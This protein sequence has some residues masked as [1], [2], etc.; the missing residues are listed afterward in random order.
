M[1]VWT[2]RRR[3]V[4]HCNHVL[5]ANPFLY[6]EHKHL[7]PGNAIA[8]SE[9]ARD[10]AVRLPYS[11]HIR[12]RDPD[13]RLVS[14]NEYYNIG[15]QHRGPHQNRPRDIIERMRMALDEAGFHVRLRWTTTYENDEEVERLDQIFFVS[16]VV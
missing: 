1:N 12:R 8:Q 5:Q 15:R 16:D 2:F 13:A 14:K 11:F 6:N 3:N 4:N 9:A 10:R 7:H